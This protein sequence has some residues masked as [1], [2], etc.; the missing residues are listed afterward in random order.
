L[1]ANTYD[2]LLPK[3]EI[4]IKLLENACLNPD[5]QT[6]SVIKAAQ[7]LDEVDGQLSELNALLQS[8]IANPA[9]TIWPTLPPVSPTP[10]DTLPPPSATPPQA[11]APAAGD[12]TPVGAAPTAAPAATAAPTATPT[13]SPTVTLTPEPTLPRP[14]LNYDAILTEVN[15]ALAEAFLLDLQNPYGTGMLDQWEQ[16]LTTRGQT[17]TNYCQLSTWPEP[18]TLPPDQQTLLDEPGTADPQL[19]EALTLYRDGTALAA[20]AREL[21]IRDCDDMELA[22]SAEQ[23]S[24]L[25]REAVTKLER[26]QELL[27]EIATRS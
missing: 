20:Q 26:A 12:A 22:R 13:P 2:A 25:V 9:P 14:N 6:N 15:A 24:T 19:E 17:T 3:F 16:A 7:R 21:Y 23:G 11:T 10:T 4:A 5:D 18:Y 1:F 27:D 8:A